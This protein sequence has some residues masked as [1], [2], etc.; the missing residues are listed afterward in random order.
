[1]CA[2]VVGTARH[3][4]HGGELQP[5]ILVL[6]IQLGGLAQIR[7]RFLQLARLIVREPELANGHLVGGLQTQDVLVLDDRVFIV[8]AREVL[9]AALE[10]ARLFRLGRAR[11]AGPDQEARPRDEDQGGSDRHT[12]HR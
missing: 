9:L 4:I 10:M 1:M 5:D 11:A 7:K 2:R 6:R 12:H 3:E 8:F